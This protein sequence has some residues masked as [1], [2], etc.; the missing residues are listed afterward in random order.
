M[1]VSNGF[2]PHAIRPAVISLKAVRASRRGKKIPARGG[3]CW[4]PSFRLPGM[5][6]GI[7][8]LP[9]RC[10]IGA[11]SPTSHA[12]YRVYPRYSDPTR[13]LPGRWLAFGLATRGAG[14]IN[15]CRRRRIRQIGFRPRAGIEP[16]S[17]PARALDRLSYLGLMLTHGASKWAHHGFLSGVSSA[18]RCARPHCLVPRNSRA[19]S[20][21]RIVQHVFAYSA[22]FAHSR[23]CPN[24]LL[25]SARS[26][27]APPP[28]S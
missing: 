16:A 17:P 8:A 26:Q 4:V 1:G 25:L 24:A 9:R 11:V 20:G 5:S 3:C 19:L 23:V 14:V 2:A 18:L 12:G 28:A 22:V 7:D 21:C 10:E 15:Q 6:P 13:E 27:T